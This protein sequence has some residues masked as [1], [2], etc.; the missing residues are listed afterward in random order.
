MR[1][2]A[3]LLVCL[4]LAG[5]QNS[6]DPQIAQLQSDLAQTRDDL[7]TAQSQIDSLQSQVDAMA[8][9]DDD[10]QL[11]QDVQDL[12]GRVD[13]LSG[14][15][16]T[17]ETTVTDLGDQATGLRTDVDALDGR[18]TAAAARSTL[19]SPL[20]TV[21]RSITDALGSDFASLSDMAAA[22]LANGA[23]AT[24]LKDRVATIEGDYLTS[25]DKTALQGSIDAVSG[26][27]A[28]IEGDYLTSTDKTE[29]AK[30][31]ANV[32]G[33][34][35]T[36]E[37]DYL[38]S[39]DKT[40]LSKSIGD[41]DTRLGTV[42]SDYLK[43]ADKVALSGSISDLDSRLA[44]VEGSYATTAE[45]NGKIALHFIATPQNNRLTCTGE[46]NVTGIV[47]PQVPAGAIAIVANVNTYSTAQDHV[48]HHFGR[49]S[50]SGTTWDNETYN[51]NTWLSD[52]Y[53]TNNGDSAG[54]DY[55]GMAHGTEIIPLLSDGT[56][57]ASLCHG[58]SSGKHYITIEAVGYFE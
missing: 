30:P 57:I 48:V 38:T 53:V 37:G 33:R 7:A 10:T 31:T 3:P 44:T 54:V 32:D 42:E 27:I 20:S 21:E 11:T 16:D 36:V 5:C 22:V 25:T 46:K 15:T 6:S 8:G 13:D 52:V 58:Y 19:A 18:V 55:Y 43:N 1:H 47:P 40:A 29:L 14:R 45:V 4:A 17:L 41:L 51:R 50:V 39:A 9:A 49:A 34:L 24:D 26:R 12:S 56:Y 2:T 35:E 28:N 23:S